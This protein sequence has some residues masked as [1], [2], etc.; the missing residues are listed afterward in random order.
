M[1]DAGS[2]ATV[3]TEGKGL[4]AGALGLTGSVVVGVASTAPAYSLA[5]TLGFVVAGGAGFKAPAIMLLAFLPM[6]GSSDIRWGGH[7]VSPPAVR[8]M[9]RR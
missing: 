7:G 6:Y 9:R 4:R 1:S 5:A 3:V 8:S 2:G